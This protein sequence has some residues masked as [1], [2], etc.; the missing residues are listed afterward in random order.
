MESLLP[1]GQRVRF[2]V[3]DRRCD[4]HSAHAMVVK[5]AGDD[6]DCTD[7]A[8]LTVDL[9]LLPGKAGEIAFVAATAWAR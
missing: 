7:G 6:P 3:H 1:N 4:A 9:R 8:H 2:D 5:F